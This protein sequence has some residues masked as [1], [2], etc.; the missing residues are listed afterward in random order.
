MLWDVRCGIAKGHGKVC[1]MITVRK[2]K[3][4][5]YILS[6][7][8]QDKVSV[9]EEERVP[10][11]AVLMRLSARNVKKTLAYNLY[12]GGDYMTIEAIIE[13]IKWL[14]LL[15]LGA[16]SIYYQTNTKLSCY[17]AKLIEEAENAYKDTTQSGGEKFEWVVNSLYAMV[18][19]VLKPLLNRQ[20]LENLV[21]ST[22]DAMQ[23][24]AM[25]Q[26]DKLLEQ[27]KKE[28]K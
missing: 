27:N 17:A 11:L 6:D 5:K 4:R 13:I 24:Y 21:Q 1:L 19:A 16:A 23:R 14:A 8:N 28:D 15:T 10:V 22:F 9:S 12:E 7:C 26:M 25:A 18:P 2:M 3:E 20:M